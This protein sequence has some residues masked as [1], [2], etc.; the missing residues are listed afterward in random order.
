MEGDAL[1]RNVGGSRLHSEDELY[2]TNLTNQIVPNTIKNIPSESPWSSLTEASRLSA[3][4]LGCPQT[5]ESRPKA[6]RKVEDNGLI[7]NMGGGDELK[8]TN[9]VDEIVPDTLRNIPLESPR[10]SLTLSIRLLDAELVYPPTT[11][12]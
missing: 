12:S 8:D 1:I 9:P 2:D 5:P 6:A 7:R 3:T 4:D 10:S 11:D